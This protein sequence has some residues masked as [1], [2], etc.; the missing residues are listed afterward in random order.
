MALMKELCFIF[1]MHLPKLEVFWKVFGDNQSCI[2]VME[3]NIFHQEQNIFL[4]NIIIFKAS[5]KRWLLGYAILIYKNKKR[6][7]SLIYLTK[8]YSSIYEEND[9]YGDLKNETF[10]SAQGSLRIKRTTKAQNSY[11]W[12]D[13]SGS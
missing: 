8:H 10:D 7:F 9:M 5:Y 1:D 4:L 6:K 13:L 2:D 3:S 12:F 11:N